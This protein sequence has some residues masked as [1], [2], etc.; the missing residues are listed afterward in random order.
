MAS[1]SMR[2]VIYGVHVMVDSVQLN[3]F[4]ATALVKVINFTVV[5]LNTAV[6]G[7]MFWMVVSRHFLP[8]SPMM[9]IEE[10]IILLALWLYFMGGASCSY[11]DG[12]VRGGFL[13]IWLNE[14]Q[15]KIAD[16]IARF[17]EFSVL[18]IYGWLAA[19]YVIHLFNSTRSAIYLDLNKS[20]WALSVV[21]GLFL[22]A[23]FVIFHLAASFKPSKNMDMERLNNDNYRT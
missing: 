3:N 11:G 7:A 15:L 20:Y 14:K 18:A 21:V 13:N 12:H 17:C 8:G 16:K 10:L 6:A 4:F 9:W 23:V 22:M 1:Q 19:K 2:G 5:V